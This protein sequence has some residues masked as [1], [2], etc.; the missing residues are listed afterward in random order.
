MVTKNGPVPIGLL[1]YAH[2]TAI[3]PTMPQAK[4]S[5]HKPTEVHEITVCIDDTTDCKETLKQ[6]N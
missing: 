1:L 5:T 4:Q 2:V 3:I 6:N